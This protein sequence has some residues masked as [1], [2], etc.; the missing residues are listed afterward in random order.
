MSDSHVGISRTRSGV[1]SI[2]YS[3]LRGFIHYIIHPTLAHPR[4]SV[5]PE[6]AHAYCPLTNFSDRSNRPVNMFLVEQISFCAS[7]SFALCLFF[8]H[9]TQTVPDMLIICNT[10][11]I[12][13][14][15]VSHMTSV[16]FY[17]I[18]GRGWWIIRKCL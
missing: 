10:A 13:M 6:K 2:G 18:I 14:A 3:T 8:A 7:T 5:T 11:S 16:Y 9:A 15:P 12:T 1:S 4:A 17:V